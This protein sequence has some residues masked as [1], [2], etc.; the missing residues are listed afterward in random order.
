[1]N[2]SML[3]EAPDKNLLD[4]ETLR[5]G[6]EVTSERVEDLVRGHISTF[7][8][9]LF[10]KRTGRAE[11]RLRT[12]DPFDSGVNDLSLSPDG[13]YLVLKTDAVNPPGQWAQYDDPNIQTAFRSKAGAGHSTRILHY[14]IMD[15]RT[16]RSDVLLDAPATYAPSDVL[17]SPDSKSLLLCGTYLPLNGTNPSQFESRRMKRF[18][19]EIDVA[20]RRIT[21]ITS[22][23]LRPVYW[24]PRTNIVQFNALASP[25]QAGVP[26]GTAFYQKAGGLWSRLAATPELAAD[27]PPEILVDEDLN[28]PPRIME[29]DPRTGRRTVRMD[30]NPQYAHLIFG[31]E[32]EIHW[33]AADGSDLIAGLYLPP[34]YEPGKRYPLVIQTHG[35]D[36]H[37]FWLD[38][39]HT[40][41]FAA[42]PLANKGIAVLQLNDIF[43]DTMDTPQEMSH[44]LD[45]YE[46]AIDYLDEAGIIDPNRVGLIGFSRTCMY[47]K[48]AVARS[49]HRFAAALVADGVD[50][51]YFQYLLY[52]NSEPRMASEFESVIGGAP[53]SDGMQLWLRNSPG[54]LL[55]RVETP[56]LIQAIGP[57]SVLGEWQWFDGLRRLGKPVEML[58]LPVGTHVL[59]RPWDRM[60]SQGT[61][62]DWFAFWLN[63]DEQSDPS[64]VEEYARWRKLRSLTL[65][66]ASP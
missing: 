18:V 36:S 20:T 46:S 49:R 30:L 21:E 53:F 63:G 38:G 60:A 48:Y 62:V 52:F 33:A 64:K 2:S 7:V 13:R 4:E 29:L 17:W 37:E 24:N 26:Q 39:S 59:V 12:Q 15:V 35:F 11:R 32:K 19:V 66:P 41:A 56:I 3:A 44:V 55:D 16:G 27:S 40:T 58:Y 22:E 47:V 25:G 8:P 57:E 43:V 61:A 23:D 9:E 34:D 51:G 5:H 1:M 50:A 65:S 10:L 42:Q 6:F 31:R 54:F 28:R 14:E 45:V